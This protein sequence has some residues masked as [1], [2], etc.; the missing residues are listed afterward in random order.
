MSHHNL[1]NRRKT[2]VTQW[3]PENYIEQQNEFLSYVLFCRNEHDYPLSLI[4]NMDEMPV[5]FNLPNNI[6]VEQCSTKTVSI[7]STG[8]EHSSFTVVLS[9]MANGTKLPP[10]IIFK[11]VNVPREEFSDGI[12]VRAN[13]KGWMNEN[14]ISW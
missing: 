2:T 3:L 14:K 6:T 4:E 12:I 7:L 8:Y 5:S 10:V 9:C 11:L 1:V 13:P